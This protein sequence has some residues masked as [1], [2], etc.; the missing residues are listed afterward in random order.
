MIYFA[1]AVGVPLIKIGSSD[2]VEKRIVHINGQSPV[3]VTLLSTMPGGVEEERELH[4]AFA[5]IRSHAEWFFGTALLRG[6]I[7]G[8][9]PMPSKVIPLAPVKIGKVVELTCAGC[10]VRF[11][12]P[13]TINPR[14]STPYHS[15]DCFN[16][17]YRGVRG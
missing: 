16:R 12:R 17:R 8:D 4:L 6:F 7:A 15:R 13:V 11:E 1:E 3:A 14:T 9:L 5:D 2:N 10:G